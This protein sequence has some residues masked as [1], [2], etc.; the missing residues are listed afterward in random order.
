MKYAA[1]FGALSGV[2]SMMNVPAVV[3]TTACFGGEVCA[4][5]VRLKP[6][7]TYAQ[8]VAAE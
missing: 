4:D 5:T 1:W 6:D 7:T 2:R 8:R 3:S